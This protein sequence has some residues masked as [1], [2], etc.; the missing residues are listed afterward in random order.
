MVSDEPLPSLERGRS[1]AAD[2]HRIE[3]RAAARRL[4]LAV[5]GGDG[6]ACPLDRRCGRRRDQRELVGAGKRRRRDPDADGRDAR[7]R[8]PRQLSY[9][10]VRRRSCAALR[11]RHSTPDHRVRRS[12]PLGLLPAGAARRRQGRAGI[13]VVRDD[14][15]SAVRRLPRQ[16]RPRAQLRRRCRVGGADRSGAEASG[17]R[18]RSRDASRRLARSAACDRGRVRRDCHLRQQRQ[19]R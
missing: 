5:C 8:H 13:Q 10:A 17:R 4:R 16:S 19:A 11:P 7:A 2:R 6:A 15:G 18:L 9:R 14:S 12:A 1:S 3:L